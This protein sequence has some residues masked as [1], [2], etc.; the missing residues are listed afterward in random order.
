MTERPPRT[1]SGTALLGAVLALALG[2]V[3]TIA[4]MV[5]LG[6][7]ALAQ[8]S[9]ENNVGAESSS[10]AIPRPVVGVIDLQ[11]ILREA[12]AAQAVRDRRE[13]FVAEYQADAAPGGAR[14]SRC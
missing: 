12:D 8:S 9:G 11:R 5:G 10:P 3:L 1:T 7:M 14:T 4:S 2:V 13:D 6:N